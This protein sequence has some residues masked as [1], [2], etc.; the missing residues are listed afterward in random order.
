MSKAE[1]LVV[2]QQPHD[3]PPSYNSYVFGFVASIV[4]TVIAYL[5]VTQHWLK[6]HAAFWAIG[7]LAFVQFTIQLMCFLH[8]G[9]E[10]KPRW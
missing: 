9:G 7:G 2:A 4:L 6:G 10:A 8:L 1:Q 5:L 3:A